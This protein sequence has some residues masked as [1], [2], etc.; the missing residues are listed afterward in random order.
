MMFAVRLVTLACLVV[1]VVLQASCADVT[2]SSRRVAKQT[3]AER[4]PFS[5]HLHPLG[6]RETCPKRTLPLPA[7][8]VA[9]SEALHEVARLYRGY[10]FKGMRVDLAERAALDHDPRAQHARVVC[11]RRVQRHTVVVFLTFPAM[12][13]S[14][15]LQQG[16]LLVARFKRGYRVWYRLH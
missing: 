4:A 12:T 6:P 1:T 7:D 9:T 15:S 2:Q 5:D 10:R 14:A 11:G 8:A 3:S 13:P 16:V